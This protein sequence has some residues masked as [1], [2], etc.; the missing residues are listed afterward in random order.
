MNRRNNLFC[1]VL[2]S[3]IAVIILTLGATTAN[4]SPA[5]PVGL[6]KYTLSP[7]GSAGWVSV[8]YLRSHPGGVPGTGITAAVA[9]AVVHGGAAKPAITASGALPASASGCNQDVC[10][11]VEGSGTRVDTWSTQAF[12]NVGCTEAF[13]Y[14]HEGDWEAPQICPDTSDPGVYWWNS[15][16]IGTYP[17]GDELCNAWMNIK[18]FP[19]IFIKA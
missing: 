5:G 11:D 2:F 12:G 8:A 10:I 19:C 4:A 6:V 9:S 15:G 1:G 13:Y 18:G 14:W 16:P 3:F 7:G 17:N